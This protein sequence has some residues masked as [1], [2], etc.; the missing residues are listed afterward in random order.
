MKLS[1][2]RNRTLPSLRVRLFV[3]AL[4][5]AICS[6]PALSVGE[7]SE[8]FILDVGING[9]DHLNLI[10]GYYCFQAALVAA[11]NSTLTTRDSIL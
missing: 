3:A 1:G 9:E 4:V 8:N 6:T 5:C 7:C 11:G 10:D 2:T